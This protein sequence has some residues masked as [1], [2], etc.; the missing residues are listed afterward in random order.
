MKIEITRTH[1][2]SDIFAVVAVV[3]NT[4]KNA[5]ETHIPFTRVQGKFWNG[6]IFYLCNSFTRNRANSVRDCRTVYKSSYENLH[7][8]PGAVKRKN[9]GC[10]QVFVRSKI[11]PE[12]RVNLVNS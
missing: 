9:A 8:S 10:V 6:R 11:C 7:G 2:L 12:R 3:V 4:I 1:F 5:P